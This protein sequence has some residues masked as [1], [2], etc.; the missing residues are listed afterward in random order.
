MYSCSTKSQNAGENRKFWLSG[1]H[2]RYDSCSQHCGYP[3]VFYHEYR[4]ICY[5]NKSYLEFR[6]ISNISKIQAEIRMF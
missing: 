6:T 1:L 2:V 5:L 4:F 3:M